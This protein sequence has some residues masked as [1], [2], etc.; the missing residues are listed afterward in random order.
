MEILDNEDYA[1]IIAWL[2]H[3]LG[4][5]IFRKKDFEL[6][7]LPK[8]FH[9][10]S[11]Y[12]SFT[13]KMNRWGYARVTRG[14]ETGAYYNE[15]FRRDGHRLCMQM[16]CQSNTKLSGSSTSNVVAPD[17]SRVP[18]VMPIVDSGMYPHNPDAAFQLAVAG[19]AAIQQTRQLAQLQQV[20]GM[21]GELQMRR[22]MSSQESMF[23]Q[24]MAGRNAR[25]SASLTQLP[26]GNSSF[27]GTGMPFQGPHQF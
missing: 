24:S 10:Q 17:F 23:L 20:Q 14:P 16:S 5:V 22:A 25:G 6:K 4:F 3:G 2:P 19:E 7:I 18:A 26:N 21:E 11:K 8:H 12:S 15:F 13:R 1:D 27:F 9:K